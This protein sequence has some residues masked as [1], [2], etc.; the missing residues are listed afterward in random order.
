[1]SVNFS[2]ITPSLNMLDYLKRCHASI[3]DQENITVEHIIMDGGSTDG[4]EEWLKQ[5]KRAIG[6]IQK[7]EGMYNA[8]NKGLS[9]AQGNIISYLSCDE[10]YL[11]GTLSFVKE[12]MERNPEVDILFGD[13]F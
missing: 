2:V 5:N 13:F 10:Q 11:S 8:I 12:F 4:T 7:D 9:L 1:M 6:V 3:M